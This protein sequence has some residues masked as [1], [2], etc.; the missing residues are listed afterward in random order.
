M[1]TGWDYA[2]F[3]L[4]LAVSLGIGVFH[5]VRGR[6]KKTT[7]EFLMAGRQMGVLPVSLS[8]LASF[9]SAI[10]VL[11]TP[12][13]MYVYGTQYWMVWIGY[14]IMI[15]LAAH[16]FLPVFYN[17]NLTS[18]FEYLEMRFDKGI[19]MFVYVMYI[20]QTLMY[21]AIVLYTPALALNIVTG[22]NVWVCVL[23]VGIVCT[24]YTALGG[25]KATMWADVFQICTMFAGLFAVMGQGLYDHGG[26]GNLWQAMQ[27]TDRV[28]FLNFSPDPEVRHTVWS[29][30]IGAAFVWLSIYGVNQS[31]VQR[32]LCTSSL[33][34]GQIALW[35]NLPGL[36]LL[37][38]I[39][40]LVGFIIVAEYKDCDPLSTMDITKDQLLPLYVVQ[41]LNVPGLPG[42]FTASV[43]SGALRYVVLVL[44]VNTS[45]ANYRVHD[46]L[47]IDIK[48]Y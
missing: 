11:G 8:L 34:A 19:R 21:M 18:V 4:M 26:L 41:R 35:V 12:A 28:E 45:I 15:P 32:A 47:T 6:K 25:M 40:C 20:V 48:I 31:Q 33:R 44:Y 36:T 24:V 9:M 3:L 1:F 46:S 38:T 13:E 37:M 5:G 42:L 16:F 23:S 29:L 17:L 22:L 27:D 2:V 14:V 10:T 30:S 43:F 39:T 7:K